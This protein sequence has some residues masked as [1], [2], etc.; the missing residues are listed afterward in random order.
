MTRIESYAV[1]VVFNPVPQHKGFIEV[2]EVGIAAESL[3]E[4]IGFEDGVC[5]LRGNKLH[6]L[7]V[8][9]VHSSAC[10][11]RYGSGDS[12]YLCAVPL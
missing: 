11:A 6:E 3:G 4:D 1:V 2:H 10:D 8:A 9:G 12:A 5:I 7:L